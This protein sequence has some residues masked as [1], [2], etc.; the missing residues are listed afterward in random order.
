MRQRR[1]LRCGVGVGIR[2]GAKLRLGHQG[3]CPS[4]SQGKHW[5]NCGKYRKQMENHGKIMV[6]SLN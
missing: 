5:E 6:K 4:K 3:S 2:K 1:T